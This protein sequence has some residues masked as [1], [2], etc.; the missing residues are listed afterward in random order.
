MPSLCP[1]PPS[2]P[3]PRGREEP[4]VSSAPPPR[5]PPLLA[6][7]RR[8]DQRQG[9]CIPGHAP[10]WQART[11]KLLPHGIPPPAPKGEQEL[12][13]TG[14]RKKE[15]DIRRCLFPDTPPRKIP[16]SASG[17]GMDNGRRFRLASAPVYIILPRPRFVKG[18]M[19]IFSTKPSLRSGKPHLFGRSAFYVPPSCPA[20]DAITAKK[21]PRS[22]L[23]N[24]PFLLP[25]L[26]FCIMACGR[27]LFSLDH[28]QARI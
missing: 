20:P 14:C 15:R 6:S 27:K 7:S 21:A 9:L 23:F 8:A 28:L 2:L 3:P 22:A 17:V 1:F 4:G 18:V 16:L 13:V 12:R 11:A 19:H 26:G 5:A 10:R 24:G 25:K